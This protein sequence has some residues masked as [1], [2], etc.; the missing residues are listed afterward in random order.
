MDTR[1]CPVILLD[2]CRVRQL[3]GAEALGDADVPHL[4]AYLD[5]IA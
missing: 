2:P 1:A 4:L 5:A 3:D